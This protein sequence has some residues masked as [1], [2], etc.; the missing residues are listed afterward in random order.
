MHKRQKFDV[1]CSFAKFL[2]PSAILLNVAR[3]AVFVENMT[4]TKRKLLQAAEIH[5]SCYIVDGR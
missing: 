3:L 2:E 4:A 5:A 1:W